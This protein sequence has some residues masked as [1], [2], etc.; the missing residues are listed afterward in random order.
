M[1]K[2]TIKAKKKNLKYGCYI[3]Y[4]IFSKCQEVAEEGTI[5]LS[6]CHQRVFNAISKG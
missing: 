5:C 4:Y 3:I 2:T 6:I 1:V